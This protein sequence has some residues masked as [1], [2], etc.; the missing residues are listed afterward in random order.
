MAASVLTVGAP[1]LSPAPLTVR[2][3]GNQKEDFFLI[4]EILIRNKDSFSDWITPLL[5]TKPKQ[6][7]SERHRILFFSSM[8]RKMLPRSN[9]FPSFLTEDRRYAS[10]SWPRM[11]TKERLPRSS[12]PAYGIARGSGY[13]MGQPGPH[14]S[15]CPGAARH[16]T[17][18]IYRH[19]IH[20]ASL[21]SADT[22]TGFTATA[23]SS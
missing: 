11:P 21:L 1:G 4:R 13:W 22:T 16:A 2:L 6:C 23:D 8:Q 12:D 19:T 9:C 20:C 7:C 10:F 14:R 3:A 17:G 18:T 5:W 15:L